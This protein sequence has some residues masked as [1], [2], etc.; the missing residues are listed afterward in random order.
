[1][2]ITLLVTVVLSLIVLRTMQYVPSVWLRRLVCYMASLAIVDWAAGETAML[3]TLLALPVLMTE[4]EDMSVQLGGWIERLISCA[5]RCNG[6]QRPNL[7]NRASVPVT[8]SISIE[9]EWIPAWR[10]RSLEHSA[11]HLPQ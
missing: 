4:L 6:F 9:G 10:G 8:T 1:M 7:A 3:I 5:R 11:P 2:F